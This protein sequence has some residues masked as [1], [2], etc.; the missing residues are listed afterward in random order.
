[1]SV[2]DA[3][4]YHRPFPF[5]PAVDG[6]AFGA[7]NE[8][9][10]RVRG[11]TLADAMRLFWLLESV[12]FS[13]SASGVGFDFGGVAGVGSVSFSASFNTINF[14]PKNRVCL[15]DGDVAV[16]GNPIGGD[17]VGAIDWDT[18]GEFDPTPPV[19][20]WRSSIQF[21]A[22]GA[23]EGRIVTADGDGFFSFWFTMDDLEGIIVAG[24]GGSGESGLLS[25]FGYT[26]V[27]VLSGLLRVWGTVR[28]GYG[29]Y[30]SGGVIDSCS[31]VPSF[32]T[33]V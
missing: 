7:V 23:N 16:E 12:Y 17:I 13:F 8:K 9:Y 22:P 1:M 29:D 18:P 15:G 27:A 30:T 4:R 3:F 11:L 25:L 26:D 19:A 2:A 6:G 31:F 33:C 28:H 10:F 20:S 32:F 5:C 24:G 21:S 14:L